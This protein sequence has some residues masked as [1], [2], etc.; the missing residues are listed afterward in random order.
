ME[1]REKERKLKR[2]RKGEEGE[3]EE[4]VDEKTN[5]IKWSAVPLPCFFLGSTPMGDKVL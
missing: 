5:E 1:E 4:D 2:E 3:E